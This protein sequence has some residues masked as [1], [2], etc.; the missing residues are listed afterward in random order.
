MTSVGRVSL[1]GLNDYW[2]V[3]LRLSVALHSCD[4][5]A[6]I[7]LTSKAQNKMFFSSYFSTIHGRVEV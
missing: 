1:E 5:P 2:I 6:Q 4:N 7:L 3:L